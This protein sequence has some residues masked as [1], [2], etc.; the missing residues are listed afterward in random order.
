MCIRDRDCIATDHAPHTLAEKT[1]D[2]P[3]PGVAGLETALPLMLTAVRAGRLTLA[4]LVELMAVN[5][6]RVFGLP[7]QPD[8]YIEVDPDAQYEITNRGLY[9]KCGWTP[10]AGM[11]VWGR[12]QRVVLRGALAYDADDPDRMA[13]LGSGQL[14]PT[15]RE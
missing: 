1:S 12:V 2:N 15:H 3:P 4:R 9:T 8:T 7:D 6:R 11:T 5:P 14:V 10:F 13:Q